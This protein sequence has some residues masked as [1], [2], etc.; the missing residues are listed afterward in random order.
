MKS[1][2]PST[3]NSRRNIVASDT[4][5][6]YHSASEMTAKG[7]L[8]V[9]PVAIKAG[10]CMLSFQTNDLPN[11]IDNASQFEVP[12]TLALYTTHN[13]M[14][15]F[16]KQHKANAS[17]EIKYTARE[18]TL[19]TVNLAEIYNNSQ[20]NYLLAVY[21]LLNVKVQFDDVSQIIKNKPPHDGK[22]RAFF[23]THSDR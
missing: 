13:A 22:A 9:F 6:L 20:D 1:I 5:P 4:S 19:T 11:T 18:N 15:D 14:C 17:V 21:R 16:V 7:K 10:G 2:D 8:S 12:I 3:G 23:R